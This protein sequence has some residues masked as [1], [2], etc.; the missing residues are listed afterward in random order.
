MEPAF[1]FL[2]VVIAMINFST[3]NEMACSLQGEPVY[4]QLWKT[5]DIIV[6]GIFPFHS[7]WEIRDLSYVSMPPPLKCMR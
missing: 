3:A 1:T 7:S 5:G 4:P 2:H 6:G